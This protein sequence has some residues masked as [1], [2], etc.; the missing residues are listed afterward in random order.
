MLLSFW[1]HVNEKVYGWI[2]SASLG[3]AGVLCA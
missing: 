2:I 3:K 1:C